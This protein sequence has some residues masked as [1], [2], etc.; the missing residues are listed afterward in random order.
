[1]ANYT[2]KQHEGTQCAMTEEYYIFVGFDA[3]KP[4]APLAIHSAT[5][6]ACWLPPQR[7]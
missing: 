2:L 5:L 7:G 3:G 6:D 1:M 4:L